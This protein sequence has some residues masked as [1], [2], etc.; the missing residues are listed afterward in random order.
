MSQNILQ[1]NIA[2]V[3]GIDTLS[4]E[5]QASFLGEVGDVIFETSL[6]RLCTD[7]SEDQQQALEEYLDTEPEPEVLLQ[8]LLEHYKEFQTIL[9]GVVVEFKEDALAV[10]K[11]KEKE[12]KIID[13]E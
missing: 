10:L 12:I 1:Q 7:L 5:E 8:H 3:L 11:E 4:E 6:V 13:A 9:E 2:S